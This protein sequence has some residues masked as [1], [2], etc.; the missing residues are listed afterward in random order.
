MHI[1]PYATIKHPPRPLSLFKVWLRL[2][3]DEANQDVHF[4][5]LFV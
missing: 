5:S 1:G 2:T 4:L 3:S